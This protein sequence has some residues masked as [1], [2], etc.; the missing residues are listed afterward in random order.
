[1]EKNLNVTVSI[2]D[3]PSI[4]GEVYD[5][6]LDKTEVEPLVER[7]GYGR[8][9]LVHRNDRVT[10]RVA[11]RLTG[12]TWSQAECK[13]FVDNERVKDNTDWPMYIAIFKDPDNGRLD[14]TPEGAKKAKIP[15][16]READEKH[17]PAS[18]ATILRN[19]RKAKTKDPV[20]AG[21]EITLDQS[22]YLLRVHSP[23][24]EGTIILLFKA[25][26]TSGAWL[27]DELMMINRKGYDITE[28]MNGPLKSQ[29]MAM[30]GANSRASQVAFVPGGQRQ[31]AAVTNSIEV[32]KATVVRV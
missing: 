9:L 11:F 26:A 17:L 4:V 22:R 31:G 6:L 2:D 12:R 8:M 15:A 24:D 7:S 19:F 29:I 14:F 23:E 18:V 32:R 30:A 25:D 5:Y 28:S 13:I 10:L 21:A 20:K 1:M 3:M 16:S 27:I